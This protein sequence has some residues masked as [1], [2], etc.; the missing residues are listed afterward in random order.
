[1][2]LHSITRLAALGAILG[3]FAC[4]KS[5]DTMAKPDEAAVKQDST[6][7]NTSGY[8]PMERDTTLNGAADSARTRPDQGQPVTAKGDTLNTGVDSTNQAPSTQQIDTTSSQ[9]APSS[10]TGVDTTS[11]AAPSSSTGVD[12]TSQVPASP[13]IDSTS[14]VPSG[15][16]G[17]DTTGH[18]GNADTTGHMPAD[19]VHQ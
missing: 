3:G 13:S 5:L 6:A 4:A 12:T 8:V 14:E 1:M 10:T 19:S 17:V 7:Q 9:V 2:R 18:M 16:S 11:Q 15:A